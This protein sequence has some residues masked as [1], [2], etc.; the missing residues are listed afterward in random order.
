MNML[1]R[2]ILILVGIGLLAG[3]YALVVYT[4]AETVGAIMFLIGLIVLSIG[5]RFRKSWGK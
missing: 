4:A 3:G 2:I 1:V 5:T